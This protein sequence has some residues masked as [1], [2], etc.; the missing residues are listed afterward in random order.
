MDN[1]TKHL[2]DDIASKAEMIAK[3]LRKGSDVEI[4]R[5]GTTKVKVIEV[6]KTAR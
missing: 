2:T 1:I 3:I 6:R 5:D 4:R